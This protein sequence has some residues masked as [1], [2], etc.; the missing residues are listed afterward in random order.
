MRILRTFSCLTRLVLLISLCVLSSLESLAA[1]QCQ[2]GFVA[3]G[4]SNHPF[5]GTGVFRS[6]SQRGGLNVQ[7]DAAGVEQDATRLPERL[8]QSLDL[9]PVIRALSSHAGTRRGREAILGL[10]SEERDAE[11]PTIVSESEEHVSSK[12]QRVIRETLAKS[13]RETELSLARQSLA[14]V[15]TSV[16]QARKEYELME[17]ATLALEGSSNGLTVP[18]LYGA[19]SSP[20][21]TDTVADTDHD[22]WL[23]LSLEDWTLEHILQADQVIQTLLRVHEWGSLSETQTWIPALSETA[24]TIPKAELHPVHQEILGTVEI[25]TKRSPVKSQAMV[26]FDDAEILNVR[27]RAS[28]LPALNRHTSSS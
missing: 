28:S 21:D 7:I 15:A 17:Q 11:R 5:Q 14:P 8:V 3:P 10:I 4:L 13:N 12:R 20:M 1:R 25:V 9:A 2:P 19:A 18:P 6:R 22:E 16:E 27:T 24:R 26:S 23:K